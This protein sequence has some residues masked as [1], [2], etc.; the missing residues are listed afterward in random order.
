MT[1]AKRRSRIR[2][3]G[4]ICLVLF[5]AAALCLPAAAMAAPAVTLKATALPIPGFPGT[6]DI[7][8]AGAEVETQVTISGSEYEG[9]PSP[10][11]EL[12]VYAPIGVK[13]ASSGFPTC[14]P[15]ALEA[16]GPAGCPKG[17]SAGSRGEGL[18]VVSFGG[19]RVPEKVSIQE[20][21]IPAGGLAFYVVGRTPASF[22]IIEKGYW[23]TAS[24]PFG[25]KLIAEV[26]L[27]ETVP[28]ADDASILSFK[29]KVGAARKQGKKTVSYITLPKQCPRGGAPLKAELK[30]LSGEVT[31]VTYN[32]PCPK[33]K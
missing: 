17:S 8:G 2:V 9:S 20:F 5:G 15:A 30:F 28:G 16:S 13:I 26:P 14:A 11:T 25:P 10:L 32:V 29:V 24:S 23:T 18:G 4:S 3:A 7:L 31:T 6:G 33:H 21:F 12:T 22:E 19:D 27:V 1:E